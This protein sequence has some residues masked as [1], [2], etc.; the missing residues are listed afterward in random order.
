MNS[1]VVLIII[2]L[3]AGLVGGLSGIGGGIIVIP[4]L[5]LLIGMSQQEA[6]GTNLAMMLP[7]IGF[8]A[9]YNYYKRGF[10][11]IKVALI[12]GLAFILGGFVG[13]K[14]AVN[15]PDL[16]VKRI[17]AVLLLVISVKMLLGK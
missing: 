8:L 12:L 6:Q 15:L 5:V 9:A 14:I 10:V 1:I 2:G 11:N 13:S 4:A 16:L 7:P 17:F 3:V